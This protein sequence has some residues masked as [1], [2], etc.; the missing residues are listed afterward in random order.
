MRGRELLSTIGKSV[1]SAGGT[2]G[3]FMAIGSAIRCWGEE[4]IQWSLLSSRPNVFVDLTFV[5]NNKKRYLSISHFIVF[6]ASQ[7]R[8]HH[9]DLFPSGW[10]G[11]AQSANEGVFFHWFNWVPPPKGREW[12]ELD[13]TAVSR[14]SVAQVWVNPG[15]PG[16]CPKIRLKEPGPNGTS[17]G[18]QTD[19]NRYYTLILAEKA[20]KR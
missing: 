5:E 1:V 11:V 8:L 7:W 3:T 13:G 20:E 17:A 15:G 12:T 18:F 16:R 6:H 19:E 9:F 14:R 2:F 4:K 10:K